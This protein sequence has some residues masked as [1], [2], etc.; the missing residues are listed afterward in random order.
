MFKGFVW[1]VLI[2]LSVFALAWLCQLLRFVIKRVILSIQIRRVGYRVRPLRPLWWLIDFRNHCELLLETPDMP[3][4]VLAVKLIPSVMPGSEYSVGEGG[5]WDRK[6]NFVVPMGYGAHMLNFGYRKCR[7][8]RVDFDQ[9]P[10]AIPVYL[11]H[12][13]PYAITRGHRGEAKGNPYR[14]GDTVSMPLWIENTL[15]L[16]MHSLRNLATMMPKG[17]EM[18]LKQKK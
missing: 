11:F 12:P 4:K 6:V 8:R 2:L 17:R 15:F 1:S 14:G 7:P 10:S 3:T 13:H 9:Y 18:I 16:D 5:A